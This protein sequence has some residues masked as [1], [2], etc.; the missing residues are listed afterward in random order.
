MNRPVRVIPC[1]LT[2]HRS[3]V[4]TIAFR[5]PRYIGDPL[6]AARIFNMKEVDE[7]MLLDITA[8]RRGRAPDVDFLR[9]LSDEC[10][11]PLTV[12]GG[13]RNI[14]DARALV[15]AGVEKVV[16]D[17]GARRDRNL[18]GLTASQFGSQAVVVCLDVKRTLFGRPGVY[19]YAADKIL[20]E[21]PTVTAAEYEKSGAG[22][23]LVFSADR[24]GSM[25]GYDLEVIRSVSDAVSIP[26]IACGGAGRLAHLREAAS[27]GASAVAAG[28]LFV[29]HGPRRAVLVNFPDREELER[30]E[31]L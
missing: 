15:Q 13:I 6:N 21:D 9:R 8:T 3:L 27:A 26:V 29:Y 5:N 20:K 19:D 24:D 4:K 7:L 28:S 12:G 31:D 17:S 11:M 25:S 30:W 16:L 14:E 10:S 1:L 18:I 2:D 22:E 23:L